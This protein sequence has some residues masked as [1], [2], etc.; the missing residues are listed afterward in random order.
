[1]LSLM[2]AKS[3]LKE[4]RKENSPW[5]VIEMGVWAEGPPMRPVLGCGKTPHLTLNT[6]AADF[7]CVSLRLIRTS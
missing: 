4:K 2:E 5:I 1:M 6:A 3:V 7:S